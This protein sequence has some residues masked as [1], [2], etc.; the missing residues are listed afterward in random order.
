MLKQISVFVENK[1]GRLATIM[2]VLNDAQ[3]DLRALSIADTSDFG[4]VRI[5][6]GD[7]DKALK[8]LKDFG[9][10]ATVTEVIGFTIS[11]HA[12]ALFEVVKA[13]RDNEINLEYSYSLMGK[14]LGEADIVIRVENNEKAAK[15]LTDKGIKL[16][17]DNNV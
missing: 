16:I 13:F 2:E 11:D 9:S 4:I 8:A 10:T 6:A 5:I 17:T 7:T 1:P 15:V 12:G 3:I 14:R